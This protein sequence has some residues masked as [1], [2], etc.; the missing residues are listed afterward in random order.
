MR[1]SFRTACRISY[2]NNNLFISF[3]VAVGF[4]RLKE[5]ERDDRSHPSDSLFFGGDREHDGSV[6][7]VEGFSVAFGRED[8]AFSFFV[9]PRRGGGD[10]RL[11]IVGASDDDHGVGERPCER[12]AVLI[13]GSIPQDDRERN[14]RIDDVSAVFLNMEPHA[15]GWFPRVGIEREVDDFDLGGGE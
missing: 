13:F 2:L 7:G 6:F 1:L 9:D 12:H 8:V 10:R 14:A 3:F 5:A 15:F 4:R 11:I